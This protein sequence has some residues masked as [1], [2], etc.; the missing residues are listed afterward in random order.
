MITH[1]RRQ[2]ATLLAAAAAAVAFSAGPALAD[3]PKFKSASAA[4]SGSNL[5]ISFRE[6]GLGN[7]DVTLVASALA[8]SEFGCVNNGG[9][10]PQAENKT[11][12][13][14]TPTSTG[15]FTPKNGVISGT[16]TLAAPGPGSFTCPPGQTLTFFGVTFTDVSIT[17]TTN[18]V[19]AAIPGTFTS[20]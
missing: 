8:T 10:R 14:D 13:T 12:I 16:L 2:G 3:A 1:A 4:T 20:R 9:R 11:S 7:E 17:D 6:I 15:T 5:V 18:N 19:T